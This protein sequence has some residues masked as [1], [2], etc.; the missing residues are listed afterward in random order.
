MSNSCHARIYVFSP[1]TD[2][3]GA[4]KFAYDLVNQLASLGTR[5]VILVLPTDRPS[6]I[7]ETVAYINQNVQ[8]K[9]LSLPILRRYEFKSRDLLK[10]LLRLIKSFFLTFK[11]I[12]ALEPDSVL[13][14]V[15]ITNLAILCTGR[16]RR[17]N[18]TISIHEYLSPL[19]AHSLSLITLKASFVTSCSEFIKDRFPNVLKK[20]IEVVYSGI[21]IDE[22][23]V[24]FRKESE[25]INILCVGRINDWKGQKF[26][27]QAF[28]DS[29]KTHDVPCHLTIVGSP[30]TGQ[31]HFLKEL[32]QTARDLNLRD[33]ISILDEDF[34]IG[35]HYSNSEI[36]IVPSI[37]PEP[38]GRTTVEALHY[39]CAVIASSPGGASEI[40]DEGKYGLLFNLNDKKGLITDCP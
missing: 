15:S 28:A 33:R 16:F 2:N 34:N 9:Y 12:R 17:L 22:K 6:L 27:I 37:K 38:F 32:H 29:I 20:R 31:E 21:S 24:R 4:P 30:L 1:S 10:T 36:V 3:Y 35:K 26:L 25:T 5:E 14:F 8:I 11:Y 39:G 23:I 40:L 13:H 7:P 19:E 18:K